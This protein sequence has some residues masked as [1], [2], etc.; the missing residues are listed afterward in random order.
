[1]HTAHDIE[2]ISGSASETAPVGHATPGKDATGGAS[3]DAGRGTRHVLLS[4]GGSGGHVFPALAVAEALRQRGWQV[5]YAG[6]S[7]GPEARLVPARGVPFHALPARPVVG[8]GVLGKV[9]ALGTLLRSSVTARSLVRQQN[10]DIVVGTGGYVAVPAVV[11]ARLAGRPVLLVEPNAQAGL[12][13][14]ALS[15]LATE[16]AI[17]YPATASA[18]RCRTTTTGIPVRAAFHAIGPLP[19]RSPIRVLVLG[20]SQGAQQLNLLV[21]AA[22]EQLGAEAGITVVHQSGPKRLDE[23]R[24]AYADADLDPRHRVEIV[25]FVDDVAQA[26]EQCHVVISRAGAITLAELCAAGR[27]S[28]LVPLSLAGG[29]QIDNARA[30][31]QAGAAKMLA[32]EQATAGALAAELAALTAAETDGLETMAR[33]ARSLA[34]HDAAATIADRVEALKQ[35]C[36]HGRK[37]GGTP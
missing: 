18:L 14:R 29:H 33:A 25:P 21:P 15:R 10:V 4:G 36:G 1:M 5:S 37:R 27:P 13:N 20:G 34:R 23:A 8:R 11:G 24:V 32:G 28:I 6:S 7:H 19:A 35:D 3:P 9:A 17:A 31:E 26:M 16:A 12:A 22:L 2:P 30:L